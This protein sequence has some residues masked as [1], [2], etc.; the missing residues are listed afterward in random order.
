MD[1][2]FFKESYYFTQLS[3]QGESR[4]GDLSWLTC[5]GRIDPQEQVGNT[6]DTTYDNIVLTSPQSPKPTPIPEHH[7]SPEVITKPSLDNNADLH[8]TSGPAELNDDIPSV[9]EVN[10]YELP[11]RRTRGVP[12]RRY[13]P[14]YEAQRSKYP[15]KTGIE[16]SLS[17]TTAAFNVSLYSNKIP[18][19]VEEALKD[20]KW[21]KAMEEEI[22]ALKKNETWEK[23]RLPKGKKTVG[24]K[25]VFTIKYHT[26][27]TIERYKAR[28]VAKGYT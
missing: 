22:S 5:L 12:S 11:P 1:C 24:C 4:S 28:L 13:D 16:A 2:E 27:G 25:W 14:E 20:P 18:G 9:E 17:E 7:D 15:V 10:K 21:R 6:A 19:N 26:D 3:P 8:D 23:C